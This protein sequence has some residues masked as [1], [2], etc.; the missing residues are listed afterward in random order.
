M[1]RIVRA[2]DA[3]TIH[4]LTVECDLTQT[5]DRFAVMATFNDDVI[6]SAR[7]VLKNVHG[8]VGQ[9]ERPFLPVLHPTDGQ[10]LFLQV[11]V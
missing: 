3:A 7:G 10:H 11:D 5:R 2:Q 1:A 4:V 8:H 6:M 9:R